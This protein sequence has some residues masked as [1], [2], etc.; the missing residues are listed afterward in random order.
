TDL[1]EAAARADREGM[2]G[3][4]EL[5]AIATAGRVA[6]EAG[7]VVGE[8]RAL[9]PL[10]H[11]RLG[12]LDPALAPVADEI[13]R[14]IEDDGADVRDT[15]SPLLRR[16]RREVRNGAA[17]VREELARVA[18]SSDVQEALQEQFL[19][20]RGGRPVLAVRASSRSKV[21]GIVHDAS[22][23]GQT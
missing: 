8:Q 23:T 14:C 22:S 12:V 4:P 16:L 13:D 19:A 15:A 2:L 5:R 9:A 1:R 20:E 11:E 10:L 21:P 17:R 7:R 3:P 18:R 6:L